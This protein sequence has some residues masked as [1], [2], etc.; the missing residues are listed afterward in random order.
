MGYTATPYRYLFPSAC[1]TLCD[2]GRGRGEKLQ[3]AESQGL[4]VLR[5]DL[6][7]DCYGSVRMELKGDNN[8][9]L[10][11]P[12]A[13]DLGAKQRPRP[14]RL[15]D[16][17]DVLGGTRGPPPYCQRAYLRASSWQAP[18]SHQSPENQ[19]LSGAGRQCQKAR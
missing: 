19:P 4:Q 16:L 8:I 5:L 11:Y 10:P 13:D 12:L 9:Q 14:H 2:I 3:A 17:Q 7:L 1:K 6:H 15:A 18:I